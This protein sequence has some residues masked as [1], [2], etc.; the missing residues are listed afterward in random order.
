PVP[1]GR[2][3]V[4]MTGAVAMT[5]DRS[6]EAVAPTPSVTFSVMLKV[7][8]AV[9]VPV[10]SPVPVFRVNPPG[11]APVTVDHVKGDV[12]PARVKVVAYA[13]PIVP[14]GSDVVVTVNAEA[15]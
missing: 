4:E 1:P 3:E 15:T 6:L 7:P 14:P 8:P 11:S 2:V 13:T 10:I 12:P 9:G 5:I